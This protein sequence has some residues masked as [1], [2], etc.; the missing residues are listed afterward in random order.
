MNT[1]HFYLDLVL[2]F[3]T[4]LCSTLNRLEEMSNKLGQEQV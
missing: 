4:N 1:S 3:S 2:T